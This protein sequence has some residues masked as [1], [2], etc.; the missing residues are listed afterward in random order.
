MK[1]GCY[2]PKFLLNKDLKLPFHW[3][4]EFPLKKHERKAQSLKPKE[5]CFFRRYDDENVRVQNLLSNFLITS[6]S[7]HLES[8]KSQYYGLQN[9]KLPEKPR[10]GKSL[11]ENQRLE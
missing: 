8:Q 1:L 4:T 5:E 11:S 10:S 7:K 3:P 9:D 2:E 6:E